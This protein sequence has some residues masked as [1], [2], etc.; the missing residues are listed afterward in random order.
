MVNLAKH[1]DTVAVSLIKSTV[2][3]LNVFGSDAT[4]LLRMNNPLH[5]AQYFAITHSAR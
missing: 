1:T 2:K 3:P 4:T 5:L